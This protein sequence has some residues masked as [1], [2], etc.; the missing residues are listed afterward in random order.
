MDEFTALADPT[1]RQILE[2]IAAQGQLS[3]SAICRN[4]SVSGPAISQHLKVL[5]QFHLVEMESRAQQRLYQINGQALLGIERWVRAMR[6]QWN[7]RL[8]RLEQVIARD[9]EQGGPHG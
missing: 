9:Q 8:D 5:R 3:A 7:A 1:R 4:F 6:E 2:L